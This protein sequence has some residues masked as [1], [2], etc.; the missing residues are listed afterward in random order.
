MKGIWRKTTARLSCIFTHCGDPWRREQLKGWFIVSLNKHI[1]YYCIIVCSFVWL[2]L[3]VSGVLEGK[4]ERMLL[5]RASTP[6]FCNVQ[7]IRRRDRWQEVHKAGWS[8]SYLRAERDCS[9]PGFLTQWKEGLSRKIW[10]EK[11]CDSTFTCESS[12]FSSRDFQ[13]VSTNPHMSH[14]SQRFAL[15]QYLSATLCC[16]LFMCWL[17][18]TLNLFRDQI[19]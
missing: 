16:S 12:F 3:K 7:L 17:K 5:I 10:G 2:R 13:I 1:K 8:Q 19:T 14:W 15:F 4:W 6:R 11:I 18:I 9:R